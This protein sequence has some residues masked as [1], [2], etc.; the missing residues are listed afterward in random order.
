MK[1]NAN[2]CHKIIMIAILVTLPF[3]G[4]VQDVRSDRI[5]SRS[6]TQKK[7]REGN[8]L[9]IKYVQWEM[10]NGATLRPQQV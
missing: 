10:S 9:P 1:N 8:L 4:Y 3:L 6:V 5:G 2:Y 7:G